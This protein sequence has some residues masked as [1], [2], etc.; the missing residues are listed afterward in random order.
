ME[1]NEEQLRVRGYLQTQAAKLS[2]A[3]LAAKVR[4]DMEQL[5]AAA[6]GIPAERFCDRP[7]AQEWSANEVMAHVLDGAKS[8]RRAIVAVLDTGAT[9]GPLFDRI[10]TTDDRRAAGEWWAALVAEREGL[11]GRVN[12]AAGDEHLDVTWQHPFFGPLNW[13]EWLLF[14]RIHDLDHARQI[15]AIGTATV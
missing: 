11:F 2:V 5:R 10:E 15:A 14:L 9:P 8:V 3:D 1:L 6:A 12:A 13:R 4:S 7:A